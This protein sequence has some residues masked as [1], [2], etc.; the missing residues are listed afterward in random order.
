MRGFL[1]VELNAH[2]RDLR[3]YG[4]DHHDD[5][6]R[7]REAASRHAPDPPRVAPREHYA[8]AGHDAL[9]AAPD[10]DAL[11]ATSGHD[12][13][14]ATSGHDALIAAPDHDALLAA[15]DDDEER[16]RVHPAGQRR[17]GRRRG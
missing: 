11:I 14:I 17:W 1:L 2:G 4:P 16:H 13:L 8:G 6:D 15:P 10:D 7:T 12:A 5:D 3:A 9:I